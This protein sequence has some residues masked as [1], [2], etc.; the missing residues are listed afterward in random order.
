VFG[1]LR[2]VTVQESHTIWQKSMFLYSLCCIEYG[3]LQ[4]RNGL[5]KCGKRVTW[6][7]TEPS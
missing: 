2:V 7:A 6:I 1:V 4:T 3:C 5:D